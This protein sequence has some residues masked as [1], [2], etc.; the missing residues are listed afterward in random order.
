MT[1]TTR[2][3]RETLFRLW[4]RATDGALYPA[5]YRDFR[6]TVEPVMFSGGAICV[7]WCGMFVCIEPDGYSHT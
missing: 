6:E 2:A 1:P 5:S 7:Q 3:Q 4:K